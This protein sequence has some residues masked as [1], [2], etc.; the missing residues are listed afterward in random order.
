[1]TD[2]G[3][4]GRCLACRVIATDRSTFY[5]CE[6]ART[7]PRFRRYPPIPVR[8]CAGFAPAAP[9]LP[10]ALPADWEEGR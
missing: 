8:Q 9:P 2:P 4:C 3:L 5:L 1:M 7:D 10:D 6:R